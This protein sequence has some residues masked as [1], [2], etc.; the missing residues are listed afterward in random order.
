M[1]DPLRNVSVRYKLALTFA[2]VCLL[3]FGLGGYLVS[4][5]AIAALESEIVERLELQSEAYARAL[6]SDLETLAQRVDDFAS[7]GFIRSRFGS[8]ADAGDGQATA[9][10]R[11]HLL[12]NKLPIVPAF[13]NLAL[14]GTDGHIFVAEP[15]RSS[16]AHA[17]APKA[18]RGTPRGDLEAAPDGTGVPTLTLATPMR[19]LDGD[20][21]IGHLLAQVHVGSWL[22]KSLGTIRTGSD[23]AAVPALRLR[24]PSGTTLGVSRHWL[25]QPAPSASSELV[26]TSF[27]LR[28]HTRHARRAAERPGRGVFASGMP[29]G[30]SGWQVEVELDAQDALAPVSGLQSRFV[31]VGLALALA[32]CGLLIFPM[33]FLARPLS[34]LSDAARRIQAGNFSVRVEENSTDEIGE[35]SH[36]FNLMAAAVEERTSMLESAANDLA[37]RTE[38]VRAERD[39]LNAVI[40]SMRDGLIVLGADGTPEVWNRAARPLVNLIEKRELEPHGHHTCHAELAALAEPA[41]RSNPCV[42]CLF[43]TTSPQRS[44]LVD[45]GASVFEVHST[46]LAADAGGHAGRVLVSHDVTEHIAADEHEIHQERLAVLGEVAAVVAHELNN[47][48]AAITMFNQMLAADLPDDSE[49]R[50]SVEV[51]ERNAQT[52]KQTIRELLDYATGAVP[53]VG[54]VDVHAT[55]EDVTRFLRALAKRRGI[56]I[57]LELLASDPIVSGDEVQIRQVFVN[58]IMNALHAAADAGGHVT[59]RTRLEAGH[60]M[61][62]VQDDGPGVPDELADEIFRPFYT[63]KPR[64]SGTG[65]G[66]PT[67]RR[68]TEMHGGGLELL[69]GEPG[70]TTFQVRLLRSAS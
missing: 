40:S 32:A 8:L 20:R 2:G 57:E 6:A 67:A 41:R 56:A 28:M 17:F 13:R 35:L 53:E 30:S 45:V 49:L 18:Q 22:A 14:V 12:A 62:E 54:P 66:L 4:G 65:L 31:I 23:G 52:C 69:H 26:R 68:I 38:E 47:P 39:R 5:S 55:L 10:L 60:L 11:A 24:D 1:L 3:T 50:E 48:L 33:R 9:E 63:T 59:V 43:S 51:I 34:A 61:V 21:P 44:C 27:G 15:V 46:R 58:L 7:D 19:S 16:W 42:E 25:A 64:G 37:R 70:R 36:S 29:I